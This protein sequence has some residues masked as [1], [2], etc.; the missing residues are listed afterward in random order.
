[1]LFN[2][3][4]KVFL[5]TLILVCT[6]LSLQAWSITDTYFGNKV[7]TVDPR[8]FAMGGATAYNNLSPMG[9]SSNPANLTQIDRIFGLAGKAGLN[10]NED[11]RAIPLYN[12]FDAYIDDAVISS[13]INEFYQYGAS[14][15]A[16]LH[17]GRL[18]L[19]GGLYYIP[20]TSFD[21]KY[22]EQI[23]NN[24]GTDND[25]YPEMIAVNAMNNSGLVNKASGV[26][27]VLY[28]IDDE[29]NVSLGFDFGLINGDVE[30][31]KSIRW[32]K[33]SE[34]QVGQGVLPDSTFTNE[35]SLEGQ[36]MK[37]GISMQLSP[38][39]GV[40]AI[41]TMKSTLDM[42]GSSRTQQDAWLNH[43]A[44][45]NTDNY[46]QDYV[47][48]SEMRFG[49]CYQPRNVVRTWFNLDVEQ[50]KWSD[51]SDIYDDAYNLYVGVEHSIRNRIPF[52]IG[53][54]S[55]TSYRIEEESQ[56]V[57]G[58]VVPLKWAK[59]T[60]TP[61]ITAGSSVAL[62]QGLS[63]DLGFGF[64]WR[65]YESLDL[66]RDSYYDDKIYT[67][68]TTYALWP[69]SYINLTDRGW[70]NPDKVSENF[71]SLMTGLS[72]VW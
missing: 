56:T 30:Q 66:F 47:L 3:S 34:D 16:N 39:L 52:R 23:R 71:I 31:V 63:L 61:M 33:W 21:G 57:G 4:H 20:L 27:S 25:G 38:R 55:V 72:F 32:T 44:V 36:Q 8:A 67:G 68:S 29:M 65:E 60:L 64:A 24:R 69:N 50:V 12:S 28:Q 1:M 9:I 6:G 7:G 49:F 53:F 54:Q 19:G 2:K 40:A 62:A 14:G 10:R 26:A 45:D 42:A 13:N 41:Y 37:A 35:F 48:P 70:D 59:K 18:R 58:V 5:I 51:I 43:T 22:L 11:N 46:D 15:F 17:L